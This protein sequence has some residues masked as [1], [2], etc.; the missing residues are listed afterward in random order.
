MKTQQ[1]FKQVKIFICAKAKKIRK[2]FSSAN[3]TK[4]STQNVMNEK[5]HK[6]LKR[7]L[8]YQKKYSNIQL[9]F[10]FETPVSKS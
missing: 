9:K 8:I 3:K 2:S 6:T 7:T 4:K 5:Q 1:A 10:K